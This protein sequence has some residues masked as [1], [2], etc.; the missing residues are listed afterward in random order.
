V[1]EKIRLIHAVEV[2]SAQQADFILF[3]HIGRQNSSHY[4]LKSAAQRLKLLVNSGQPVALVD[5]AENFYACQ[6]LLP[7]AIDADVRVDRLAAY[8]GWN[9]TSNS[10][11]TAVTQAALYTGNQTTDSANLLRLHY[12]NLTFVTARLLDDW[13]YLK[14]IQP[15]IDQRLRTV[16]ADPY[17]LQNQRE[18]TEILIRREMAE[19]TRSLL[20]QAFDKPIV[21][22]GFT[23]PFLITRIDNSIHLPWDRTFEIKIEP[24]ITLV[25]IEP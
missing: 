4:R 6:T 22:P 19:R 25:Q 18:K 16:G 1:T 20:R 11:G 24:K 2:E 10:I 8:A 14:D 23:Q 3:V 5:L 21:L 15:Q 13:Y 9:T 12:D 17:Q 7:H